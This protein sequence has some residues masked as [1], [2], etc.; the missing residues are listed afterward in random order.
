MNEYADM[1]WEEFRV[2]KLGYNHIDLPL[3][4]SGNE[5]ALD[6]SAAPES[7]DWRTKNAV[8]PVKDQGQCGSCWAFR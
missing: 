8:T 5:H 4:R 7:V 6:A 3:L 1:T 2:T